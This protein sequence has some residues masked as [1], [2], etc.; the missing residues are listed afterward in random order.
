MQCKKHAWLT[1]GKNCNGQ[2]ESKLQIHNIFTMDLL[3]CDERS[4]LMARVRRR[5]TKPELQLRQLLHL[6]GYRYRTHVSTLPG[7]PD[8]VF[9][10]KKKIIF[11]HGCFWHGHEGCKYGKTPK[12]NIR[13]WNAKIEKNRSRDAVK[14]TSLVN[15]GWKVLVIWE[16]QLKQLENVK[17]I[18]QEFLGPPKS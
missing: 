4:E 16:C 6:L 15:A 8:I 9:S 3:T 13:F 14:T 10:R 11:V 1:L 7:T 17:R 18:L 2:E 5:D 12:S